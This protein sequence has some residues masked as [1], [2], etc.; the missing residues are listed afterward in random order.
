MK[1]RK[2][3]SLFISLQILASAAWAN[4]GRI[5]TEIGSIPDQLTLRLASKP[6]LMLRPNADGVY[7]FTPSANDYVLILPVQEDQFIYSPRIIPAAQVGA[8]TL[9]I[10]PPTFTEYTIIVDNQTEQALTFL[11]D[12]ALVSEALATPKKDYQLTI[13]P[14]RAAIS[15][16]Y[17]A[18]F[19]EGFPTVV[20]RVEFRENKT[21]GYMTIRAQDIGMAPV[22]TAKT[23]EEKAAAPPVASPPPNVIS[24]PKTQPVV[25]I[26]KTSKPQKE[27]V[28]TAAPPPPE[29]KK[30]QSSAPVVAG[31][32]ET[33]VEIQKQTIAPRK[34]AVFINNRFFLKDAENVVLSASGEYSYYA[35][36]SM[37]RAGFL[38]GLHNMQVLRQQFDLILNVSHS[39]DLNGFL[40]E[41]S[42]IWTPLP[43][44]ALDMTYHGAQSEAWRSEYFVSR[45]SFGL[46]G[47]YLLDGGWGQ[48]GIG[49]RFRLDFAN[50]SRYVPSTVESGARYLPSIYALT[51]IN[52]KNSTTGLMLGVVDEAIYFSITHMFR[53]RIGLNYTWKSSSQQDDLLSPLESRRQHRLQLSY[54][55]N[56]V[57]RR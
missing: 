14:R 29:E 35:S 7:T 5:F 27:Q 38:L 24:A 41:G 10:I 46:S 50:F 54:H 32:P 39:P 49:A 26:E 34:T 4:T 6:G 25:E 2:L 45:T 48:F 17:V 1:T 43:F 56:L 57:E 44:V 19:A 22:A 30:E 42:F 16:I 37:S 47:A 55:F 21:V 31:S 18:A 33:V 51:S 15:G 8:D 12:E 40:Y 11:A 53:N 13:I 20:D 36:P 28:K 52:H 9:F 3:L 23:R